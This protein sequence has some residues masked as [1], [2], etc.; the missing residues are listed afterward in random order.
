MVTKK[1]GMESTSLLIEEKEEEE[2]ENENNEQFGTKFFYSIF[3]SG[4]LNCFTISK[5]RKRFFFEIL[6]RKHIIK[7][8]KCVHT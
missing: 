2:E 5:C 3:L 4:K 1:P 7:Y 8:A 6:K